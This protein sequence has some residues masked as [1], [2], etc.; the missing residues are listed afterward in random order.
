MKRVL[1]TAALPYANGVLHF[2]HIAGVYLPAD[3]FARF[4]RLLGNEV[5]FLCGSDEYGVAIT[6]AAELEKRSCKEH[7]DLFHHRNKELFRQ[8]NI[9]F[10]YYSRTTSKEHAP[11]VQEF[12]LDL[13][14]NGHIEKKETMQLFSEAENR[15][16]ADRYVIGTCPKCNFDRARGDECTQCGASFEATDLLHPRS[17]LTENPLIL[18]ETSHWF[19][20]FDHFKEK[21]K[22][23]LEHRMWRD[24]VQN[25]SQNLI[26]QL[27]ERAITRDLNWGVGIPLP[28]SEGK[29]FYV[30]FDA[31]IGYISLS[32]EWAKKS[33]DESLWEKFWLDPKTK[34]VQF[35]GKDNIPFHALFFPAMIMGQNRSYKIVDDLV[36]SEFYHLEGRQFSKS[37]GWTIDLE[38]FFKTFQV[39]QIRYYLA[40][41]SPETKDAEF[42][43][44][45][46]QSHL[47]QDL[48][49][50][51][52]NF[53]H[54]VLS[55]LQTNCGG[56][57]PKPNELQALDL[58]FENQMHQIMQEIQESYQ[59]YRI[60]KV[61]Q[62]LM[63]LA[64]CGNT[65]FDLKAP[66]KA[67]KDLNFLSSMQ[68]TL[69][70]SLQCCKNLA[71]AAF[72]LMPTTA[73]KIF[74]M[75]GE[76]TMEQAQ[77]QEIMDRSLVAEKTLPQPELLFEKVE[78][79]VIEKKIEAL[80]VC[81]KTLE[82]KRQ[83]PIAPLK[84][85]INIEEFDKID[86]RVGIIKKAEKLK[87]SKK[88]LQLTID[89]G[90]EERTILSGIS[91][92]YTP[93]ELIGKKVIVVAN[94]KP[95]KLMGIESQGM[96]LAGEIDSKLELALID[97][98]PAGTALS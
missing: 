81:K 46:F 10:D 75:L 93:E 23:L 7:V 56:K 49:G 31:P 83:L 67:R 78:E 26:D 64:S 97:S 69:F 70:L 6:L 5:L 94:L 54:R 92:H 14:E 89:L 43:W 4:S 3:A 80:A 51:F 1:I 53:V 27:H 41:S 55:F 84:Q 45:A 58:R 63:E 52:G 25:F 91:L 30:W 11:L 57:I 13:L 33:G 21:L 19:L 68:T 85:Q 12:F 38:E 76:S 35:I 79:S 82:E 28:Q 74:K 36:A 66:W 65:Y 18:K 37:E 73:E 88:L 96:I 72:P 90:L 86:L 47:N 32:Q 2:G 8:L 87:K 20:H 29:V 24:N 71:L 40:A 77:W 98:L 61:T 15:F 60:K 44:K 39:D 9:S 48:V 95:A 34:Y 16:L 42:S 62:L 50:K 59:N 22:T 17:K